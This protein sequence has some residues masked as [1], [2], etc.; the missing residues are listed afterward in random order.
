MWG[1]EQCVTLDTIDIESTDTVV[2]K[3][4]SGYADG[5]A[6]QIPIYDEDI[7]DEKAMFDITWGMKE[8]PT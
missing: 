1:C 2:M 7:L 4:V 6:T 3:W 5:M 8:Y